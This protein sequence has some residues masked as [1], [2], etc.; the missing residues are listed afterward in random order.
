MLKASIL[1]N[2][3]GGKQE[4][5]IAHRKRRQSN[6]SK[7]CFCYSVRNKYCNT[8]WCNVGEAMIDILDDDALLTIFIVYKEVYSSSDLSWWRPLVRVCRRWRRVIFASPRTA[9]ESDNC[10]HTSKT[11]VNT[12]LDI[13]PPFSIAIRY[14]PREP[15]GEDE[16]VVDTLPHSAL[17]A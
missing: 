8:N 17:T 11:P 15:F 13:W 14:T 16:N 1:R 2:D 10:L 4:M 5:D 3:H 9:P 12:S 7:C 6:E